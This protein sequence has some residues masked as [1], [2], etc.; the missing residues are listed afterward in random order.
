MV[1]R[2]IYGPDWDPVGRFAGDDVLGTAM[3]EVLKPFERRVL[4][5]YLHE[6]PPEQI[7]R[8][9]GLTARQIEQL[10]AGIL[11]RLRGSK[12][13][14]RLRQELQGFGPQHSPEV[15]S[16]VDNVPVHRCLRVGCDS[17]PFLQKATGHPRLYCSS[18]CRQAA[19]RQRRD[20]GAVLT[21][22]A[23]AQPKEDRQPVTYLHRAYAD[24]PIDF[25]TPRPE[26]PTAAEVT[27]RMAEWLASRGIR[28]VEADFVILPSGRKP[29][30]TLRNARQELLGALVKYQQRRQAEIQPRQPVEPLP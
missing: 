9:H 19:Y 7:G 12:Y 10:I 24:V 17:P 23:S 21:Q 2:K 8:H 25:P 18:R 27:D 6:A 14:D 30:A 22:P 15:W 1:R 26:R 5:D 13:G 16:A 3:R 29:R 4:L 11:D 20:A 28:V